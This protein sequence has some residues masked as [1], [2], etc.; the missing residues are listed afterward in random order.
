MATPQKIVIALVGPKGSGKSTIGSFVAS[1][2]GIHFLRVEPLF[3]QVRAR[4]GG[5]NDFFEQ[6]G[7]ELVRSAI[8]SSLSEHDLVCF[9]STGASRYLSLLLS[10]LGQL[11][12]VLLVHVTASN[13]QCALRVR[14]R[15]SSIH[16]P[17]SDDR[18]EQINALA[19]QVSLPWSAEID[20][21]EPFNPA[22]V[23]AIFRGLLLHNEQS[24]A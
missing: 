18:L 21:S 13:D 22:Q 3:L 14:S 19:F 7:F 20:N 16:I 9:E 11:A 8:V 5:H 2:L 1:E 4:L 10:Q 23:L 15:D 6:Q 12:R 17:V 24:V